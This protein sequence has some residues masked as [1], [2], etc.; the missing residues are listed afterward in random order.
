MAP[1][2]N[3][4]RRNVKPGPPAKR[5]TTKASKAR[6]VKQSKAQQRRSIAGQ[7]AVIAV[8]APAALVVAAATGKVPADQVAPGALVVSAGNAIGFMMRRSQV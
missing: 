8:A 3:K 2:S 4:T 5:N 6:V 1:T 7:H